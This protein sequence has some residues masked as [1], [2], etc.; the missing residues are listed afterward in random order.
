MRL[1]NSGMVDRFMAGAGIGDDVPIE[2]RLV[3]RSIASAQSQVE[4]QNFEIRK[5]VLKYD[6]VLNR[7]REVIYEERRRVLEGEDLHEQV[8]GFIEDVVTA[9]VRGATAEGFAEEWDLDALWK[10]LGQALPG[11]HHRRRGSSR[12]PAARPASPA[13][14]LLA[15][16]AL[17]RRARLRPPRGHAGR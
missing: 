3:T 13:S 4:G 10:A 12:R 9:Y 6:D 17:G 14:L 7:Q 15:E 16:P 5:N 8:L 11:G 1:F 2:S